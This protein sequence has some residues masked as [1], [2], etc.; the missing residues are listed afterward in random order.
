MEDGKLFI[1]INLPSE[2]GSLIDEIKALPKITKP[3]KKKKEEPEVDENPLILSSFSNKK[4]DKK[5]KKR[6]NEDIEFM[7]GGDVATVDEIEEN[8]RFDDIILSDGNLIDI[9]EILY[10]DDE[11]DDISNPIIDEQKKGYGKR[12]KDNNP[13]KKEFA[14]ELTLLYDLLDE[15]NKFSKELD[16]KYKEMSSAKVRGVSKY[17]SDLIENIIASKTSKLQVLKEIANIKKTISD[18]YIKENAKKQNV[19]GENSMEVFATKY[20]QNVLN[21]GRGKFVSELSNRNV[22]EDDEIDDLVS[23]IE[24]RKASYT[25]HEEDEYQRLIEERLSDTDNPFR[26]EAGTKYIQYENRGVKIYIKRCIDNGEWEFIAL[27]RDNQQVYD[28][29]LPKKRDVGKVKFKDDYATDERGRM[30]K[31]I[32]YYLPEEE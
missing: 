28:Y 22:E 31:V 8:D 2:K 17:T 18:L 20:L 29:P 23:D 7:A 14:E 9:D 5:K 25:S 12:K 10:R 11:E 4:K 32:E 21:Y 3:P 30:Y 19:E 6:K 13:Y 1:N 24:N 27:D 16:R 26:S 15:M